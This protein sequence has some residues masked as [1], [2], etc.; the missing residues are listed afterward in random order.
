MRLGK[1][2]GIL[3]ASLLTGLAWVRAGEAPTPAAPPAAP[4]SIPLQQILVADS[5]EAALALSPAP[6]QGFLLLYGPLAN[7]DKVELEK[8]LAAG[9]GQAISDQ[10][11]TAIVQVVTLFFRQRD[12]PIAEVVVPPQNIASGAV[13]LAVMRG[14]FREIKFQ[15]NRWFSESM[16]RERLQVQSG[17][18]IRLSELDRAVNW[19]NTNPFRRVR[20]HVQPVPDTGEA[21][22]YVGVEE[23]LPLRLATSYD[24]TGNYILGNDRYTAALT[25]GNVWGRDHQLSYQYTTTNHQ[26]FL[27]SHAFDYRVPLPWRHVL[28]LSGST[29][30]V[31]ASLYGGYFN[32]IGRSSNADLKY[33]APLKLKG[34]EAELS[35]VFS[36]KQSNNNLE[37]G[38]QQVL[39]TTTDTFN[40]SLGLVAVRNDP[41]GRWIFS[42]NLIGSPGNVNSRNTAEAFADSRGHAR[43]SY[44]YGQLWGQRLT[45]LAPSVTLVNRAIVQGG[46]TTNLL[47]SEQF[48][49]GGSASVRGYKERIFS[50]EGGLLL[51]QEIQKQLPAR[52]L[53]KR[54]PPLESSFL[55]FWDYGRTSVYEPSRGEA[56]H[57]SLQSVGLGLRFNVGSYLNGTI[58]YGVQARKTI[59]ADPDRSRL[60]VRFTIAY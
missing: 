60:H 10:L 9:K 37:F 36:F 18:I 50:G 55:F 45:A 54:L 58:D 51:T 5:V 19:A 41:R 46:S 42:G 11:L 31:A 53:G 38:G 3:L 34:W 28:T 35:G 20:V 39:G 56:K 26:E 52:P 2:I 48:S 13:R 27:Q 15:G 57:Q 24:N 6:D 1:S 59:Y 43:P 32:Q 17:E 22:L 12:F 29:T 8:R 7:A 23:R 16:L 14:K 40:A 30:R 47:P 4:A 49:I 21:D 33:V 44:L 25:Y